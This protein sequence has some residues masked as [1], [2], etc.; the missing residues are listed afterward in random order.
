MI[1]SVTLT[2]YHLIKIHLAMTALFVL[3]TQIVF[4]LFLNDNLILIQED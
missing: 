3:E 1:L 4:I 2:S